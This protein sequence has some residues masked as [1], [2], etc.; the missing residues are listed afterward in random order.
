[1][2]QLVSALAWLACAACHTSIV[3]EGGGGSG[4]SSGAGG[5]GAPPG[6]PTC[7]PAGDRWPM[8]L[9]PSGDGYFCIDSREATNAQYGAFLEAGA[10]ADPYRECEA[11]TDMTPKDLW[12]YEPGNETMPVRAITWCQAYQFCASGGRR[13][14]GSAVDGSVRVIEN[15]MSEDALSF[16]SEMF[17]AC[18]HGGERKFVYGDEAEPGRCNDTSIEPVPADSATA[19]EG[20]YD[21][22]FF[23]Q[24]NIREWE[25]MCNFTSGN[26]DF[27]HCYMRG[28]PEEGS[29][30]NAFAVQTG[31]H[32][33]S[34]H[35]WATGIGVRCCAD[36]LPPRAV[37]HHGRPSSRRGRGGT[38]ASS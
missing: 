28:T 31:I 2:R 34:V 32:G 6:I 37:R 29:G 5:G 33:A 36:A 16:G 27:P 21:G 23:L 30:C 26:L 20:G 3:A 38:R 18:S 19:C 8:V 1:M 11:E 17:L 13:L 12:P 10:R 4:L 15:G 24:G 35:D 14:C 25:G 9:V 7:P 22:I